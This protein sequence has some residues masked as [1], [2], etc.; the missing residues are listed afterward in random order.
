MKT[1]AEKIKIKKTLNQARMPESSMI[2]CNSL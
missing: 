2:Q 1:K